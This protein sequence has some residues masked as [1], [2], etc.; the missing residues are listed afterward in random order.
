MRMKTLFSAFVLSLA[1]FVGCTADVSEN[2]TPESSDA[3][4]YRIGVEMDADCRVAM[5][6]KDVNNEYPLYWQAGDQIVING[7]SVSEPLDAIFDGE[8][9]AYFLTNI[10][11]TYPLTV[12]YPGHVML[13]SGAISIP[14]EQDLLQ[15]RLANGNG[16]LIGHTVDEQDALK[17]EHASAYIRV[18]ITGSTTI[19]RVFIEANGGE[20]LS[21]KFFYTTDTNVLTAAGASDKISEENIQQKDSAGNYNYA[22]T[23]SESYLCVTGDVALSAQATDI[24]FALPAGTYSKGFSVTIVDAEGKSMTKSMGSASGYTLAAGSLLEMPA[25]A[26]VS[27]DKVVGIHNEQDWIAFAQATNFAK[28]SADGKTINLYADLDFSSYESV[29]AATLDGNY[30]LD[31]NNHTISGLKGTGNTKYN[32]LLFCIVDEGCKVKNLTLGKVAGENADSHLTVTTSSA[33]NDTVF[34]SPF[35][36]VVAGEL[37]NCTNNATLNLKIGG[38]ALNINAGGITTGNRH[39]EIAIGNVRNCTNNGSILLTSENATSYGNFRIGGVVGRALG[40]EVVG[41]TNTGNIDMQVGVASGYPQAGG[42]IGVSLETLP[43]K[44]EDCNNSGNINL[45]TTVAHTGH[46]RLGGIIGSCTHNVKNCHN[47]GNVTAKVQKH[48]YMGGCIGTLDIDA[49]LVVDGCTNKGDVILDTAYTGYNYFGG[50]CGM[51]TRE[52]ET[53]IANYI[54]N[55]TNHGAVT[56]K[57]SGRARMGGISGSTCKMDNNTNYGAVSYLGTKGGQVSHIGG[58]AGSFGHAMSNCCNYGD[59]YVAAKASAVSVGGFGGYAVKRNSTQS[60]CKVDCK[61]TGY[62]GEFTASDGTV[63][64]YAPGL[65]FGSLLTRKLTVGTSGA[66]FKVAGTL[67]CDGVETV[68]DSQDKIIPDYLTGGVYMGSK[69]ELVLTYTQYESTK[70]A[71]K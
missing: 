64:K 25:L 44:I 58:I 16:I 28:W 27:S 55:C 3:G 2:F 10:V 24:F 26:Y 54:N 67:V 68:I 18:P 47:T 13:E 19:R 48:A 23:S 41:C 14:T 51:A 20:R 62:T 7:I 6:E 56:I 50:V 61:V 35:C 33:S 21:G 43:Q 60:G 37:E 5:G 42:V 46:A 53:D 36:T 11:P 29:P 66:P 71:D 17:V 31:G 8:K 34:S 22:P 69:G 59:V 1:L 49:S 52:A 38:S 63:T 30:T 9:T 40:A 39:A 45:V 4:M 65:L 57:A 70:P 32:S 15:D 12:I